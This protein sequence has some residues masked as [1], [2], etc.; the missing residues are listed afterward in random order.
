MSTAWHQRAPGQFSRGVQAAEATTDDGQSCVLFG[1]LSVPD[2]VRLPVQLGGGERAVRGTFREAC[3]KHARER[4][5]EGPP[6][7]V[8]I[9]DLGAG[10]HVAE[11]PSCGWVFFDLEP[12][13]TT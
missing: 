3:P 11:C 13:E 4:W 6:D 12:R 10:L 2:R 8:Q 1:D 7:A 5:G 9:L